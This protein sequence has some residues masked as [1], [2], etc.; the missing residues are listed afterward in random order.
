MCIGE[1]DRRIWVSISGRAGFAFFAEED[2]EVCGKAADDNVECP[3]EPLRRILE[4]ALGKALLNDEGRQFQLTAFINRCHERAFGLLHNDFSQ[5]DID[6]Y[7]EA[8]KVEI[9]ILV[10]SGQKRYF[11]ASKMDI[12][13]ATVYVGV[14][15]QSLFDIKDWILEGVARSV[16]ISNGQYERLPWERVLWAGNPIGQDRRGNPCA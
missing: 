12:I 14:Y 6:G 8:A 16:A 11:K 13:L 1:R 15:P 10:Q 4:T 3:M 9:N 5:D 2:Y 7:H